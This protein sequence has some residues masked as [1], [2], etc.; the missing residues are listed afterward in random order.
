VSWGPQGWYAPIE[1]VP[2]TSLEDPSGAY[3]GVIDALHAVALGLRGEAWVLYS[4][5]TG[6]LYAADSV[7]ELYARHRPASA[8][9][10]AVWA[11][12][13]LVAR[14]G[15]GVVSDPTPARASLVFSAS[16]LV[17]V[18]W[19][20]RDEPVSVRVRD[21]GGVWGP[22]EVLDSSTSN[23]SPL[24]QI[25]ADSSDNVIVV[26][27]NGS[28]TRSWQRTPQGWT[29]TGIITSATDV[30]AATSDD[31]V[32]R[33]VFDSTLGLVSSR[34]SPDGAAQENLSFGANHYLV[35]L[36]ASVGEQALFAYASDELDTIPLDGPVHGLLV[37]RRTPGVVDWSTP[38]QYDSG[39]VSSV[40]LALNSHGEA[41]AF[42]KGSTLRYRRFGSSEAVSFDGSG[43]LPSAAA[44]AEDG[45]ALLGWS[46]PYENDLH[47]RWVE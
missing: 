17:G 30:R 27:T 33:L 32:I 34:H 35:E 44:L 13:E 28:G 23:G 29:A 39:P 37:T 26:S 21:P 10:F 31:G 1:I 19:S 15:V 46:F 18:V 8:L 45:R 38:E 43:Y 9:G 22:A 3:V 14:V 16:G 40:Q 20:Q 12:P 36:A 4:R 42:W 11:P 6:P 5:L 24:L 2:P 25:N 41:I 7:I 47:V